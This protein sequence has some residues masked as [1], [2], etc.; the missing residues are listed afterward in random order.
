M[1]LVCL[2]YCLVGLKRG[3]HTG[4]KKQNTCSPYKVSPFNFLHQLE[5]YTTKGISVH[6]SALRPVIMCFE[7]HIFLHTIFYGDLE[8]GNRRV[9]PSISWFKGV[10]KRDFIDFKIPTRKWPLLAIK[11]SGWRFMLHVRM[12]THGHHETDTE[13]EERKTSLRVLLLAT[14]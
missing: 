6:P 10:L 8:H 12:M 4:D 1:M 9:G 3:Q 2:V 13:E 5:G 11:R 14:Y 7:L